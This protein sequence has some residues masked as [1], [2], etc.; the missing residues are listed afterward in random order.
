VRGAALETCLHTIVVLCAAADRHSLLLCRLHTDKKRA[1]SKEQQLKG[2]LSRI[3]ELQAQNQQL[4]EGAAAAA[5]LKSQ[6]ASAKSQLQDA[7]KQHQQEVAALKQQLEDAH[8]KLQ[9]TQSSSLNNAADTEVLRQQATTSQAAADAAQAELAQL[10]QEHSQAAAQAKIEKQKLLDSV[11]QL[12]K[13]NTELQAV[14]TAERQQ[15]VSIELCCAC[16]L[17]A[18]YIGRSSARC[19]SGKG[20]CARCQPN[21]HTRVTASNA[22]L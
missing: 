17:P 7:R 4:Q 8:R 18:G 10:R 5:G 6:L 13:L 9:R 12:I 19:A 2:L 16:M 21:R 20:R 15:R 14:L 3:D 1:E 11:T 22:L